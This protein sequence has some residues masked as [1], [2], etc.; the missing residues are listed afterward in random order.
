MAIYWWCVA[1]I[2]TVD[3]ETGAAKGT[4]SFC[5]SAGPLAGGSPSLSGL[6]KTMEFKGAGEVRVKLA[7]SM[8]ASLRLLRLSC[9]GGLLTTPL[10]L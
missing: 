1:G 6:E 9:A 5:P 8:A 4:F 3:V 7:A 2:T 10:H